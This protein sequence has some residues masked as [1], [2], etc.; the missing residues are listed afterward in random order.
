MSA[1]STLTCA[2]CGA[3]FTAFQSNHRR[4]WSRACSGAARVAAGFV[5]VPR[6]PIEDRFWPKVDKSGDCW[7]WTGGQNLQGYGVIS[8]GGH[9]SR[10]MLAHRLAYELANG[11]IP[12]GVNVLHRCDTPLCV[13]ADHLF[14]G[15]QE[16]NIHDMWSKGRQGGQFAPGSTSGEKNHR[17][18]LTAEQVADIRR[19]YAAGGVTQDALAAE[20]GVSRPAI[21]LIVRGKNWKHTT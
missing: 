13:R 19:R 5:A 4:Y 10:K 15:S 16:E 7:L 6:T 3:T 21:G 9:V 18:R 17:A 2:H 14:L 20:Y 12:E 11:P 8:K 1:K